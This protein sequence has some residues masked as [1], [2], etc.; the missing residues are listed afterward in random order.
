MKRHRSHSRRFHFSTLLWFTL[1]LISLGYVNLNIWLMSKVLTEVLIAQQAASDQPRQL[2]VQTIQISQYQTHSSKLGNDELKAIETLSN[3]GGHTITEKKTVAT[4]SNVEMVFR[5]KLLEQNL[6]E[7]DLLKDFPYKLGLVRLIG[8]PIQENHNIAHTLQNLEFLLQHEPKFKATVHKYWILNRI[9]D[10]DFLNQAKRILRAHNQSFSVLP[11]EVEEY[12][13]MMNQ[14]EE[15][16]NQILE[17]SFGNGDQTNQKR[18]L[19]PDEPFRAKYIYLTNQNS[20]RNFALSLYNKK[21]KEKLAFEIEYILPWDGDCFLSQSAHDSL[22][23][24]LK[25]HND[26]QQMRI[27]R[28]RTIITKETRAD[29]AFDINEGLDDDFVDSEIGNLIE[30]RSLEK[31]INTPIKYFYTPIEKFEQSAEDFKPIQNENDLQ[32]IF[33]RTAKARF[34]CTSPSMVWMLKK[35]KIRGPW[36]IGNPVRPIQKDFNFHQFSI[37]SSSSGGTSE[38]ESLSMF[39]NEDIGSPAVGWVTRL[40]SSESTLQDHELS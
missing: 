11:F 20:A 37:T 33:H 19:Y 1:V 7:K 15:A 40:F 2:T 24:D 28:A 22:Q 12:K 25:R 8:N 14:S 32:L 5:Q 18:R 39:Q 26:E 38:E 23:R 27:A 3:F 29:D 31:L 21:Q 17:N 36:D 6:V 35:L 30:T 13:S 16:R 10:D 4:F 9:S 34:D